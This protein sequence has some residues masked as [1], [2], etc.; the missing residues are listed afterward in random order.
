MQSRQISIVL[1]QPIRIQKRLVGT[2][3]ISFKIA[4]GTRLS[5]DTDENNQNKEHEDQ[6]RQYPLDTGEHV[7][8]QTIPLSFCERSYM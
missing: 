5:P 3:G 2:R 6:Q 1:P 7:K 4:L 8:S